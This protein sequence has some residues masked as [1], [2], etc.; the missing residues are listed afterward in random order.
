MS[1]RLFS[2]VTTFSCSVLIIIA[3]FL[4][5]VWSQAAQVTLT[6]DP[7]DPAPDGYCIYSRAEGQAY[8]Y[9]QPCWTGYGT[10]GTV[11]GLADNTTYF[12]VVRAFVAAQESADS[13][14][15]KFTNGSS[16]PIWMEAEDGD[17]QWPMAIGDETAASAGGYVGVAEGTGSVF[18]ASDS[19]GVAQYQFDVPEAGN[20]VIWG[21]QMSSDSASDSFFVSVDGQADMVWYTKLGGQGVW[22]WDVVSN[23]SEGD[24]RDESNPQLYWLA[25][26]FHTLT[27]KHRDDGTKLDVIVI[28]NDLNTG[29]AD[30]CVPLSGDVNSDGYVNLL[31]LLQLRDAFGTSGSPGWTSA[32]VNLDGYVNLSDLLILRGQFGQ[33]G[34]VYP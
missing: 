34:C 27:I 2:R 23:R 6:W 21:R 16:S 30:L 7:N 31:D 14:E 13:N 22:T 5:P 20:Y 18:S 24:P 17:L 29:S 9:N 8:D 25:A 1:S 26:G 10:T 11:A 15:V 28:T 12:F 3:I 19:N 4:I 32:D 33:S